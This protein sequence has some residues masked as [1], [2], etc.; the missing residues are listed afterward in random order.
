[1][2]SCLGCLNKGGDI[3]TLPDLVVL[4]TSAGLVSSELTSRSSSSDSEAAWMLGYFEQRPCGEKEIPSHNAHHIAQSARI[5]DDMARSNFVLRAMPAYTPIM[6]RS[7]QSDQAFGMRIGA[8]ESFR[9]KGWMPPVVP[10]AADRCRFCASSLQ[11]LQAFTLG[12][13]SSGLDAEGAA[14]PF[15]AA[16]LA[17]RVAGGGSECLASS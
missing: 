4:G 15:L 16:A 13:G 5:A 6:Q 14:L 3:I 8:A 1:M 7:A 2:C 17:E 10:A 11:L 9:E 12:G